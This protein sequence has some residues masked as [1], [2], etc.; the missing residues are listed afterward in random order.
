M[1]L[2]I[3]VS[4]STREKPS[5]STNKGGKSIY[6]RNWGTVELGWNLNEEGDFFFINHL[7]HCECM[8]MKALFVQSCL[9]LCNPMDSK[10]PARHLCPWNSPGK[11][12]GVGCHSLTPGD[13]PNPGIKPALR[14]RRPA[15]KVVSSPS[16]LPGKPFEVCNSV[17][18]RTLTFLC[19]DL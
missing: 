19:Y 17:A 11:N 3:A 2:L 10:Y 9:T 12:T 1:H 14:E 7:N 18:F 6:Y 8:K 15:L 4:K 5:V 13:L 16:E